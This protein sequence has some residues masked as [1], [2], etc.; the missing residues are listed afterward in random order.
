MKLEAKMIEGESKS[1][2]VN[3]TNHA[4]FNLAGHDSIERILDHSI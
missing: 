1:C 2:P 3:L 4:Y